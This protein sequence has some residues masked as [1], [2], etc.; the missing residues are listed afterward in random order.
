MPASQFM[1]GD[2]ANHGRRLSYPVRFGDRVELLAYQVDPRSSGRTA[3]R[4][5]D[6]L[7]LITY[8]RVYEPGRDPLKLFVHLLDP[9]STYQGGEDRLDVWYEN[10]QAEDLFAQVQEVTLNTDAAPGEYQVEIGWYNPETMQ[11]L[12][13]LWD[14]AAS[15]DRVLLDPVQVR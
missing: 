7:T 11:R 14:G 6:T 12:Q 4:P 9:D 2:P 13:V 8:W 5:G 15:I 10:W 1:P 3:L